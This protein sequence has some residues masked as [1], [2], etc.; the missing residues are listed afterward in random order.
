MSVPPFFLENNM[1]LLFHNEW[2]EKRLEKTVS[3]FGKKWFFGKKI[4]ELGACHGD[5]GYELLKLGSRV[6]FTDARVSNLKPLYEKVSLLNFSPDIVQLDQEQLYNLQQ[7]FD[8]IIHFGVLYNL[9]NWKQDLKCALSHSNVMLLETLV[10][11]ERGIVDEQR[12]SKIND[13]SSFCGVSSFF[14]E[15]TVEKELKQLGC[16][17]LKIKDPDLNCKGWDY[18][19]HIYHLYDWEL[20][21]YNNGYYSKIDG[22]IIDGIFTHVHFRRFWIVLK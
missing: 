1:R 8:L 16:N 18:N 6:T 9:K 20:E 7:K 12:K 5:F 4:L 15:E 2:N 13:Y 19:T 3:I 22:N 17:F 10:V 14:T 21:D 11:P